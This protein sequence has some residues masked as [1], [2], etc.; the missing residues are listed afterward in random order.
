MFSIVMKN[1]RDESEDCESLMM[2]LCK[3]SHFLRRE[4]PWAGVREE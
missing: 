1:D 4:L 2:S 3:G